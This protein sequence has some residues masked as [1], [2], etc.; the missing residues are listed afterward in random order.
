[1]NNSYQ[2]ILHL[3]ISLILLA[4]LLASNL[5][6]ACVPG[7]SETQPASVL[8]LS[9]PTPSSTP[10][11]ASEIKPPPQTVQAAPTPKNYSA[12]FLPQFQNNLEN[13]L[14]TAPRYNLAL[15]VDYP[16][17]SFTGSSSVLFTNIEQSPLDRIFFRLYPNGGKSYGNGN[18]SVNE[19]KVDGQPVVMSL[20]QDFS[21]LEVVLPAPLSPGSQTQVDFSFKGEASFDQEANSPEQAGYGI[22]SSIDGVMTLTGW[23]PLLAVYNEQGWNL[24]PVSAIGDSVFSDAAFFDVELTASP[25]LVIASTGVEIEKEETSSGTKRRYI[26]G[27]SRDFA[28]VMSPEFTIS[29]RDVGGVR[30]NSY[31]LP[32]HT[33]AGEEALAI[34][35]DSLQVYNHFF[36]LY[37][38]SELDVV[39]AP[40][41]YA[42]GIEFPGLFLVD[43]DLYQ[44]PQSS[45]FSATVAHETAHQWWYNIVGNDVHDEPWLDE[46]LATFSTGLFF[47]QVLGV[48]AGAGYFEYLQSRYDDNLSSGIDAPITE[49]LE[50]F[51]QSKDPRLYTHAA[52]LKTGLVFAALREKIGDEAFYQSLQ[53]YFQQNIYGI[54]TGDE[55]RTAFIS[56]SGHPLDEFIQESSSLPKA[57]Q[58]TEVIQ[59][60]ATSF[61]VIGDY[62]SG[63]NNEQAVADLVK[64]WKPNFILTV[65]DNNYPSGSAKSID[66]NIGQ[67]YADFISPYSGDY[68]AGSVQNSFYPTLGNHDWDS[69]NAQPY[70]DYFTLPGNERYYEFRQGPVHFFALDS[71]SREPDG[72]G[73]SSTQAMWLKE[74]LAASD[75]AWKVVYAHH[76]PYSSGYHGSVDWMRW[77]FKEWG[78]D[79]YLSGHDHTY[80]R[81]EV[82]GFPYIINGLGGG[83]IYRFK[84]PLPGSIVRYNDGYGALLVIANE[85]QVTFQFIDVNGKII[86][87][88]TLQK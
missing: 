74:R 67:F 42:S 82:D 35:S 81:L 80:E 76:P 48:E 40:L 41:N 65:G 22:F 11:T 50:F 56:T 10:I 53:A 66:L 55:L 6:S 64:L 4:G 88:F 44:T 16:N 47:E 60:L 68:G 87:S 34:T 83:A 43:S 13:E 58:P 24:D 86:D 2:S 37:P 28:L 79:I 15:T 27:P 49:S 12:A 57:P 54:G 23:F 30:I 62:G 20:S 70:L 25:E 45:T 71:D 84:Q 38:F 8:V 7:A 33:P 39:E 21:T 17:H 69:L 26:S 51:E 78:A 29:Q 9:T 31:S 1:M 18:I 59:S 85:N 19:V 32:Q 36:G 72:V 52:Y 3:K 77:P 46:G 14:Q 63:D 61:A 75:A 5:L 73:R